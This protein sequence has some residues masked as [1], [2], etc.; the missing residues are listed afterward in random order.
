MLQCVAVCCS[1]LQSVEV[2]RVPCN[3]PQ[4]V[5]GILVSR[6]MLQCVA[7]RYSAQYLRDTYKFDGSVLQCVAVCCSVL[8][9]VATCYSALQRAVACRVLQCSVVR[10]FV[11]QYVAVRCRMLQC[12]VLFCSVLHCV[13][14]CCSALHCVAAQSSYVEHTSLMAV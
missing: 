12:A 9:S 6:R 13:A 3:V 14:V 7:V 5:A 1:V 10:C 8:Q 2:C 11:L 4:Y